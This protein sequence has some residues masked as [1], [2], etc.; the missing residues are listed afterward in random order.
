MDQNPF[1]RQ[2]KLKKRVRVIKQSPY[3]RLYGLRENPFPTMAMFAPSI[4]DPRCNGRIYDKKFRKKEE[5]EFFEKFI[6]RPT[7]DDP[8]KLGFVN[9]DAAAGLR[10]NGKSVFLHHIAERIN[11]QD[12]NEYK[13]KNSHEL[14]SLAVHVLPEPHKR[15]KFWQFI[16]LVF[17]SMAG[18]GYFSEIDFNLRVA[19]LMQLLSDEE[20]DELSGIPVPAIRKKLSDDK[21][22]D[23]LNEF[24]LTISAFVDEVERA[25]KSSAGTTFNTRFFEEFSS[26]DC[27]I[28]RLWEKWKESGF[29]GSDYQ[30]RK[31][32]IDLFT[33]GFVPMTIAAGYR[34]LY[35]LLDEFEKIYMYQNNR[36][37]DEFLDSLRQYF[38]ERD[39]TISREKHIVTVL[40]I[41]PSIYRYLA[42]NWQRVGLEYLAPLDP[43][44]MAECSVELGESTPEKLS[45]LLI[46]YIDY[47]RPKKGDPKRNTVF[48]F[49]DDALEP[50]IIAARNYP[51]GTLWYAN[52][53]LR[54]AAEKETQPPIPR[55]FVQKLIDKGMKPPF[56]DEDEF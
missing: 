35:I 40:T 2:K 36:E 8:L 41:H 55:E 9:V 12:W 50:A 32:G 15:K 48:P 4:N 39:S 1:N 42:S 54:K 56:E 27:S 16:Q 30:W 34:R 5:K 11:K 33:D 18:K 29:A 46:T 51:R 38:Y 14:F 7:G 20:I 6:Q 19:I 21:F 10:G 22:K 45:H 47:F 13:P 28:Y 31:I 17:E 26:V 44:R 43:T 25:M 23:L 37:R 49:A 52:A 3:Q 53:I 24:D